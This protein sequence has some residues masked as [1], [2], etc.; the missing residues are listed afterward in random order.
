MSNIKA[1]FHTSDASE[2]KLP[3]LTSTVRS[4][5]L[6]KLPPKYEPYVQDPRLSRHIVFNNQGEVIHAKLCHDLFN[7][8]YDWADINKVP[9]NRIYKR[10]KLLLLDNPVSRTHSIRQSLTDPSLHKTITNAELVA[11]S[12]ARIKRI[13]SKNNPIVLDFT[14]D[15]FKSAKCL[16]IEKSLPKDH[17]LAKRKR[18]ETEAKHKEDLLALEDDMERGQGLTNWGVGVREQTLGK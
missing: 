7:L 11:K 12:V 13:Y 14:A 1:P 18:N 10:E 16:R 17:P 6:K 4:E 9:F 3:P 2:T 15:K 8:E 5:T